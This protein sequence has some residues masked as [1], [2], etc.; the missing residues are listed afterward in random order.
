MSAHRKICDCCVIASQILALVAARQVARCQAL[1]ADE[2]ALEP[3]SGRAL[4][5]IV[6][7]H[8]I[9]GR[10][11][12]K[13]PVHSSHAVE[14][15][16]SES[17]VAQQMVVEEVQMPS[18][19]TRDFGEGGIHALCVERSAALEERILVAEVAVFGAAARHHDGVRD[20]VAAPGDQ[21]CR[22]ACQSGTGSCSAS[23]PRSSRPVCLIEYRV[24][25]L[26]GAINDVDHQ[27]FHFLIIEAGT[28][29]NL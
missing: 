4:D 5:Q 28:G 15:R 29:W 7:E 13:Q 22:G 21:I 16:A 11:A 9:D 25:A 12:L 2:E 19:Q 10:R 20:Q 8:R 24:E 14:Q 27:L 3:G 23:Q 26:V 17:S 6:A 1:E 18:G